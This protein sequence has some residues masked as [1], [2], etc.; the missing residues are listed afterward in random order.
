MVPCVEEMSAA[1]L[2]NKQNQERINSLLEKHN[3]LAYPL[4][5]SSAMSRIMEGDNEINFLR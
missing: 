2:G 5:V 1:A 3:V 4:V